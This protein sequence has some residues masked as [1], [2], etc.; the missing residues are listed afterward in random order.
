M[1]KTKF[2]FPIVFCSLLIQLETF[3]QKNPYNEVSIASPTAASLGKYADIPV[4]NHTG[5][6]GISIPIYSVKEGSLELPISLSYHAG[7]LKV[8]ETASW[9]GAGWS[10]NA[11]GVIT[12]TVRG[13][14]DERGTSSVY[15]QAYGYFSDYGYSKYSFY[16][17]D[18]SNGGLEAEEFL[19]GK[20]DG[21]PDLF[22]FNVGGLS[23]KFYFR[24]DRTPIFEPQQNIKVEYV[25]TGTESIRSFVLTGP[26]GIRYHFGVKNEPTGAVPIEQTDPVNGQSGYT[27]GKVISSWFLS[28]VE[29]V[30]GLSS[31]KLNYDAERYSYYT[32]S[33]FPIPPY[34]TDYEYN[35]V[36][37]V[38][39]GVRLSN[40]SFSNGTINFIPGAV[41][42][43]LANFSTAFT[44]EY[45]N[46][47]AKG[48]G[49]IEINNSSGFCK[50]YLFS[51][52]YFV[53]TSALTGYFSNYGLFTD[54]KRLKLNSV[55]EL[56][57]D[58]TVT[59][60]PHIFEY[61]AEAVP[62]RLSFGQDHW[63]FY[64]GATVNTRLI[65]TFTE[66]E[67]TEFPGANRDPIWPAMRAGALKKIF[68]PTGGFSEFEFEPNN[69]WAESKRYNETSVAY[70]SVGWTNSNPVY[71]QFNTFNSNPHR[72]SL[73][74]TTNTSA[75]SA[76][77]TIYDNNN[78][79]V[80]TLSANAG[81][82]KQATQF[83][84]AGTY[85]LVL[86]KD[87]YTTAGYG[88]D[89]SVYE[90][91]PYTYARNEI[92]GGLRIKTLTHS[93]GSNSPNIVTSY[94]Y[95]SSNGHSSGIL[96]GRPT[97][98]QVIR[99]DEIAEAGMG[100]PVGN[101]PPVNTC[102]PNGCMS[103]D[104]GASLY[105]LI[106][107]NGIRPLGA[108]QGNHIGYNE[109]KITQSG[110]GYSI[111]RYY[112]SDKWDAELKDVAIRD[113]NTKPPCALS[114]PNYPEPPIPF[115]PKRGELKYEGHFAENSSLIK[116]VDYYRYFTEEP[117]K[118]PGRISSNVG[119]KYG[120]YFEIK[121][122]KKNEETVIQRLYTASTTITDSS[123]TYFESPYHYQPLRKLSVNS[124]GQSIE[125]KYKYA[126]D[127]RIENCDAIS[128]CYQAY[129]D[130]LNVYA[131]KYNQAKAQCPTDGCIWKN[132]QTYRSNLALAR[133]KYID[134]RKN[135]L[136]PALAGSYTKCR[137]D[138][139]ASAGSE[140]KPILELVN[141][142]DFT[143]I[144]V[145]QWKNGKLTGASFNR[146]D[147][148][149]NPLGKAYLNKT[150]SLS[151]AE[152]SP[153]FS[154]ATVSGNT[155]TVNI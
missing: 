72:I 108:S 46:T 65:P 45:V 112:G 83:F 105:Y 116:E 126:A 63:G 26:D 30:D 43:D 132:Y 24:D 41:R 29:S 9:V 42:E 8:M 110:N 12:R 70:L 120:T 93:E 75:S 114:I 56:T 152:S 10:L 127:F 44:P 78:I 33:M 130:S 106:S 144:E 61:F 51:Y 118:T 147:Y 154:V 128:D 52:D 92:V 36:K 4:N 153:V 109:V 31:I 117:V 16:G 22:S 148:V 32:L 48:L 19:A 133:R 89:A 90:K 2:L 149:T 60:P 141:Q 18:G 137:A 15:N 62:R 80:F 81:E 123:S 138:A 35:L 67:F 39:K 64:N 50:K 88:A 95:L 151:L 82:T 13:A 23:G 97:Y 74:N 17:S 40:I 104:W 59:V 96:Y 146:F 135:Y 115:E 145:S 102:N 122:L 77:L 11:G 5:I 66:N 99:S 91:I 69:S 38:V 121:A 134:C 94:S 139:K 142:N 84:N 37:N 103:C 113:V 53:N 85:K 71:E 140:L 86:T 125:S 6:P 7:G 73:Y 3:A 1:A 79:A 28:K 143:P 55:Q 14:P 47:E 100:G 111:Y 87:G 155:I 34:T 68:Y 124:T 58:G 57:C 136:D 101:N 76:Y 21:E 150:L 129:L 27:Q 25:Y 98:V 119:L 20:R 54:Q 131:L 49:S 107:P